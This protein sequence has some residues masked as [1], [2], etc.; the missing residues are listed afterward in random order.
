MKG[1]SEMSN[2]DIRSEKLGMKVEIEVNG[3]KVKYPSKSVG[4]REL[5]KLGYSKSDI[6]K[7]IGVRYQMVY[8]VLKR[9]K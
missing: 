3:K 7:M 1:G 4:I 8:N 6:S 9:M 2:W 5:S